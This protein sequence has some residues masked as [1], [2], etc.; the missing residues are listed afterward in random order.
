M[1]PTRGVLLNDVP[2][3]FATSQISSRLG[4]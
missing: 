2:V 3:A 1:Q 4:G